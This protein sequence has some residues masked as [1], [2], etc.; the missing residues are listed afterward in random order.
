MGFIFY[1]GLCRCFILISAF[2][3]SFFT[4]W[5]YLLTG[6]KGFVTMALSCW[7]FI[8]YIV[9][10]GKK[11]ALQ[12]FWYKASKAE[13]LYLYALCLYRRY[14][15]S[16][17]QNSISISSLHLP[18]QIAY[19]LTFSC[20]RKSIYF[21]YLIASLSD[22][23]ATPQLNHCS[24]SSPSLKQLL[25]VAHSGSSQ[26]N[27]AAAHGLHWFLSCLSQL[28]SFLRKL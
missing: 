19:H 28:I 17:K 4:H 6:Q 11:F 25:L 14:Q 2:G 18:N 26:L 8:F 5:P 20:P 27:M 3:L 15:R 13:T 22:N 24:S 12:Q 21:P 9:K 16:E 1:I 7:I 23:L 10:M